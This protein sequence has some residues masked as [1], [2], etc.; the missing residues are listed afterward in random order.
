MQLI[1]NKSGLSVI[2]MIN[3]ICLANNAQIR[4]FV[5]SVACL[6]WHSWFNDSK[7]FFWHK[8]E[9]TFLQKLLI[10]SLTNWLI[11]GWNVHSEFFWTLVLDIPSAH[12]DYHLMI[13]IFIYFFYWTFKYSNY[14]LPV[15]PLNH[16]RNSKDH[17]QLLKINYFL[18]RCK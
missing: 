3:Y 9:G 1:G 8:S 14:F 16:D 17:R 15:V 6:F 7:H 2:P 11:C 5:D 10:E 12:F 18:M 13:H 4:A